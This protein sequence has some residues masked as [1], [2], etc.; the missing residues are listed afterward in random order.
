MYRNLVCKEVLYQGYENQTKNAYFAKP[1]GPGPFPCVVFIHHV[2]GWNEVC[3]ETVR[4]FAHH[5]YMAISMNLYAAYGEGDAD[6]IGA[7]ARA[8]GGV[9]DDQMLGDAEGA[10]AF[11]RAQSG[12]NG[13]VGVM[14]FC[15]GGRQAFLCAGRS[16]KFD[17][18]V[19][20][21]GGRV[22]VKDASAL[23]AKQ[24]VAPIDYAKDINCPV[25][26][27]FGNDDKEPAP[28]QVDKTEEILK[29]LGKTYE[30]H[31]YDGAGHAFFD[32]SRPSY[33]PEQAMDGWKKIFAFLGKHLA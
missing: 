11:L 30:F 31:R 25:L 10:A 19:D 29:S 3:I 16:S 28:D 33:R 15:S 1:E 18:V 13:K 32:W 8:E 2:P 26:G 23:N 22:M 9:S 7:R 24:P 17:A 21:W 27:L 4:R 5:G 20:C 12:S 6:D 14:G